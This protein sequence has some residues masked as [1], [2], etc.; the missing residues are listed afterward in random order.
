M[1][2][3]MPPVSSPDAPKFDGSPE[4][5]RTFL[6]EVRTLCTNCI[7]FSSS[8]QDYFLIRFTI[9][10]AYPCVP[11]D[12]LYWQDIYRERRFSYRDFIGFIAEMY[13]DV[14]FDGFFDAPASCTSPDVPPIS[15]SVPVASTTVEHQDAVGCAS[16]L[17]R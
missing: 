3:S 17:G 5:L 7:S 8:N 6:E 12:A 16:S 15:D 11:D 10:F 14:S 2:D 1:R 9:A 4:N 13:P